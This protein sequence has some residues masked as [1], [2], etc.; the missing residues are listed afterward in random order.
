MAERLE[1]GGVG[2]GEAHFEDSN[3]RIPGKGRDGISR[4]LQFQENAI[5]E[6]KVEASV[7]VA[8]GNSTAKG[9]HPNVKAGL[10]EAFADSGLLGGFIGPAFPARKFIVVRKNL[11]GGSTTDQEL[12]AVPDESN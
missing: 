10:F 3:Y 8:M 11:P 4:R 1:Y 6:M 12:I 9:M 2:V 7:V 5:E